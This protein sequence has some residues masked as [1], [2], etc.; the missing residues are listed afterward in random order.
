MKFAISTLNTGNDL[1]VV[2]P[3]NFNVSNFIYY[4]L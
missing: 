3:L 4:Y 2:V 1:T